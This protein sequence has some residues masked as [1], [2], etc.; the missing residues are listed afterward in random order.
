M[1]DPDPLAGGARVPLAPA[2]LRDLEQQARDLD[3]LTLTAGDPVTSARAHV[4]R[5]LLLAELAALGLLADPVPAGR[6]AE[7]S[8]L[9]C[10]TLLGYLDAAATRT[11]YQSSAARRTVGL[12][13]PARVCLDWFRLASPTGPGYA[14]DAWLAGWERFLVDGT[15]G[16]APAGYLLLRSDQWYRLEWRRDDG[17]AALLLRVEP[18]PAPAGK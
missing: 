7:L 8:R 18:I 17:Q 2:A 3:A 13:G 6:P 1:P 4:R 12:S 16:P 9:G 11:A 10:A 15:V 5:R 14:P